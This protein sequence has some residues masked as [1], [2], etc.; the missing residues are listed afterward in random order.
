MRCPT[1]GGQNDDGRFCPQCGT[2]LPA[3]VQ[4]RPGL[5]PGDLGIAAIVMGILGILVATGFTVLGAVIMTDH[6]L[7]GSNGGGL[8]LLILGLILFPLSIVA[9]FGIR[10]SRKQ[11][12][13]K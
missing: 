11:S 10:K 7:Q 2:A 4:T 9:I 6:A 8:F 12:N 1:C 3:S 5:Q 13:P